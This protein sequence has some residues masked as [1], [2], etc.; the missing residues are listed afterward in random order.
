MAHAAPFLSGPHRAH[1]SRGW[2]FRRTLVTYGD[3]LRIRFERIRCHGIDILEPE[4]CC[5]VGCET[6]TCSAVTPR[7]FASVS[8]ASV[9]HLGRA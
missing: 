1:R 6:W 7:C 3:T 2:H 8:L 5:R 4:Q 9:G